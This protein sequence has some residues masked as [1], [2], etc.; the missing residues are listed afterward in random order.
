MKSITIMKSMLLLV[1]AVALSSATAIAETIRKVDNHTLVIR[2]NPDGLEKILLDR[3]AILSS[4]DPLAIILHGSQGMVK[5]LRSLLADTPVP[6]TYGGNIAPPGYL[7][8]QV[9]FVDAIARNIVDGVFC[10]GA[11]ISERWVLTAAHCITDSRALGGNAHP[12]RFF[13]V[14]GETKMHPG[15]IRHRAKNIIVHSSWK[16][17]TTTRLDQDIALVELETPVTFSPEI[18]PVTLPWPDDRQLLQDGAPLLVS[19][20][21]FT[22]E[23]RNS[24]DL[25]H[26]TV[27]ILSNSN[28]STIGRYEEFLTGNMVCAHKPGSDTCS[29]DSGG[30]AI[31]FSNS[32]PVLLGLASWGYECGSNTN[33]G[34]YVRVGRYLN[35]LSAQTGLS[36]PLNFA[37]RE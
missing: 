9:G 34:V 18:Q 24:Y 36:L 22:E 37:S 33:P 35:W 3:R 1:I 23:N 14:I 8:W 6:R 19:G 21:G 7:P 27:N 13:M 29:N 2:G 20:W 12:S 32:G 28:C 31:V 30:P 26:T 4:A 25:L 15:V 10:G 16:Q 5:N 11:L 17:P